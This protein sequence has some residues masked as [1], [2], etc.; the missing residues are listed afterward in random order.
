MRIGIRETGLL[1]LVVGRVHGPDARDPV[2][3]ISRAAGTL[4]FLTSQPPFT[5]DDPMHLLQQL[6]TEGP[7]VRR[8]RERVGAMAGILLRA[9]RRGQGR[10]DKIRSIA[11]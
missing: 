8:F 10:W 6:R 5:G 1:D 3:E 9:A 2:K 7:D 11:Q 4:E